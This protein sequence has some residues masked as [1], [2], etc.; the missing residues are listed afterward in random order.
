MKT[1]P[2]KDWRDKHVPGVTPS[3]HEFLEYIDRAG[4]LNCH[5]DTSNTDWIYL[6]VAPHP[7]SR[8]DWFVYDWHHGRIMRY[9]RRDVLAFCL[10]RWFEW[11]KPV[12]RYRRYGQ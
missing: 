11:N 5:F 2:H 8:W 6:G 3:D 9:R 12:G 7:R 1:T 4:F 10:R